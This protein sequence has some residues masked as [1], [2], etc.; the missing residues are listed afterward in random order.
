M[1]LHRKPG[2]LHLFG[3]LGN[4]RAYLLYLPLHPPVAFPHLPHLSPHPPQVPPTPPVHATQPPPIPFSPPRL[5][6][7]KPYPPLAPAAIH[8][9]AT[10]TAG[11]SP[12]AT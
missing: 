1:L 12:W 2:P 11:Q 8:A 5:G 10:Q 7:K 9:A 3:Y 4:L 6:T